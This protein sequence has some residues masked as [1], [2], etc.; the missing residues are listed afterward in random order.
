MNDI[1]ESLFGKLQINYTDSIKF[2]NSK[3]AY[4]EFSNYYECKIY[5]QNKVY[6][7]SEH[8]YQASKYPDSYYRE[9]IVNANTP[10]KARI[11][12]R[13]EYKYKYEWMKPLNLLISESFKNGIFPYSD[14]EKYKD[15]IM[16][17]IVLSKFK[18]NKNLKDLLLQ[19]ND[20]YIIENSPIDSYWGIGSDSTGTNKLGKILCIVRNILQMDV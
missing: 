15:L 12:A 17:N 14:F 11:L 16:Y 1:I 10:N 13:R 4:Y 19:T 18:D 6:P 5:F 3:T 8:A 2:Y 20:R 7:S 9:L